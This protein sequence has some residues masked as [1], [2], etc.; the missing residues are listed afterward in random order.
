[1]RLAARAGLTEKAEE[2]ARV[3]PDK[4]ARAHA[5]LELL[6]VK[7]AE[8][9]Q[10]GTTAEPKLVD[11]MVKDKDTLAYALGQE[12]VARHNTR[13][14]QRSEVLDYLESLEERFRP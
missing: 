5:Q 11:D 4:A 2:L 7:L 6:L 1:A 10:S 12:A 9:A 8:L 3:M 13:L 14:G